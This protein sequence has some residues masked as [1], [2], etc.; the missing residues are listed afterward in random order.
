MG[1][2]QGNI[3]MV[4]DYSSSH[5]SLYIARIS[6]ARGGGAAKNLCR[7]RAPAPG[8]GGLGA[9]PPKSSQQRC[10]LRCSLSFLV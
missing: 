5:K 8:A 10:L 2:D 6:L 3:L 7:G 4:R 9:L 1:S